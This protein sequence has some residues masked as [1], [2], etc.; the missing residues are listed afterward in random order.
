MV[1]VCQTVKLGMV[2]GLPSWL[3]MPFYN[4]LEHDCGCLSQAMLVV[5]L[6]ESK[7]HDGGDGLVWMNMRSQKMFLTLSEWIYVWYIMG[8]SWYINGL[9]KYVI[10]VD[11]IKEWINVN[12]S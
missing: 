12:I 7:E 5:G 11:A 2:L 1:K 4:F 8:I 9:C 6:D 3:R 10:F